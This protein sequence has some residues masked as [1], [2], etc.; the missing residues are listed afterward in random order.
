MRGML[1]ELLLRPD[2]FF[3]NRMKEP[4]SLKFPGIIV[5][6]GACIYAATTYVTSG[7]TTKMFAQI[8]EMAG[9]GPVLG[10]FGV[11]FAFFMFIIL[12]WVIFAGAFFIIS[13]V[14]SG[15]GTF[16]RTLEFAGYGL[17][18][19]IFGS[20]ISLLIS[21]YYIP[22]I[23][24]PVLTSIQDPAAI[25]KAM[26]QLMQD[27]AFSELRLLSS[28][29]SIIFLAWSANLWIFAIKHSRALLLKH[30]VIAVLVPV[31]ISLVIIIFMAFSGGQLFGGA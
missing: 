30:A 3:S 20:V 12:W 13:M 14:F 23:D 10:I 26:S 7:I 15:R 2:V 1:P 31:V 27:P 5:V 4:E 28:I 6:I 18:P 21:L 16:K 9:M 24:V 25:T 8:P 11:I 17:I 19:V 22:F 29:I